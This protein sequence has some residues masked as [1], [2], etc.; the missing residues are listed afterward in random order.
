M[1]RPLEL[2]P[3]PR[4][5]TLTYY[6]LLLLLSN[7][8]IGAGHTGVAAASP[9]IF[10][11]KIDLIWANLVKFGQNIDKIKAKFGRK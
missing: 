7:S 10:F 8:A 2:L 11:C 9:S 5:F 6:S 4:V 1:H 3:V